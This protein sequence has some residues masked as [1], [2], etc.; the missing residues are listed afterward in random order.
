MLF[1]RLSWWMGPRPQG[2]S[3]SV[4]HFQLS[5]LKISCHRR[6]NKTKQKES[7]ASLPRVSS[8]RRHPAR[9]L[10]GNLDLH[11]CF[12]PFPSL[13]V[14]FLKYPLSPPTSPHVCFLVCTISLSFFFAFQPVSASKLQS[15]CFVSLFDPFMALFGLSLNSDL[16]FKAVI[17][18]V[19]A[20]CCAL[21]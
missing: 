4:S 10:E 21:L 20:M 1:V 7:K 3:W 19:P 5:S 12:L 6:T 9:N 18:W 8:V 17:Y 2:S 14:L 15:D 16:A 11:P 13:R